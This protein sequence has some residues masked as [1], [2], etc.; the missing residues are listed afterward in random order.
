MTQPQH[1][2]DT[3]DHNMCPRTVKK[4]DINLPD[5]IVDKNECMASLQHASVK[6]TIVQA[7]FPLNG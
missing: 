5:Y 1:P 7:N 2:L 4:V 6:H 3:L